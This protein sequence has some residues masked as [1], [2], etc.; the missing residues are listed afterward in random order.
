M[1]N[2]EIKAPFSLQNILPK[3]KCVE[4][5]G[6]FGFKTYTG[7]RTFIFFLCPKLNGNGYQLNEN[8]TGFTV[9]YGEGLRKSS[10]DRVQKVKNFFAELK[11]TSAIISHYD[12]YGLMAN[13]EALMLFPIPVD[14]L[15][16]PDEIEG[17]K[18]LE[19]FE[20]TK[21]DIG[22][23]GRLLSSKPWM[24]V[25]E[26]FRKEEFSNLAN[27]LQ[28]AHLPKVPPPDNLVKDFVERAFAEYAMEGLWAA[29]GKFGENPIFLGTESPAVP[30]LQNAALE[31]KDWIPYIQLK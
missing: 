11:T 6:N 19:S 20:A 18:I 1:R 13:G 17:I 25:P 27:V 5:F 12:L 15:S 26:K 16:A 23:F 3:M 10:L 8:L 30:I 22:L 2:D 4:R 24:T 31:P 28:H 9:K 21:R 29:K 7:P 14:C